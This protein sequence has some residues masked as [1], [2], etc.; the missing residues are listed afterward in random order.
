LLIEY[1]GSGR[2]E[3]KPEKPKPRMCEPT[4][5]SASKP[6]SASLRK[7]QGL[8]SLPTKVKPA[9]GREAMSKH[10]TESPG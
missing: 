9:T 2:Q 7:T 5:R 4:S 1:V 3:G 10:L 6:D 8:A